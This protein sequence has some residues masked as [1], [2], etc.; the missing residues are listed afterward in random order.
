LMLCLSCLTR[1]PPANLERQT[2]H[3]SIRSLIALSRLCHVCLD[4][5]K[6]KFLVFA[7]LAKHTNM[8]S[9]Q[10]MQNVLNM[11]NMLNM[12]NISTICEICTTC[13][14]CTTPYA[15]Q[16][17]FVHKNHSPGCAP[18]LGWPCSNERYH[19]C[20]F[21]CSQCCQA[22]AAAPTAPALWRAVRQR[23]PF[24]RWLCMLLLPPSAD[25]AGACCA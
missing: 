25:D 20:L 10:N 5:I 22:A 16:N 12:S 23:R 19:L 4:L 13:T 7:A 3:Q 2:F 17:Y 8:Q 1:F 24:R 9:M 14:I 11:V 15:E 21:Q 18:F 6:T